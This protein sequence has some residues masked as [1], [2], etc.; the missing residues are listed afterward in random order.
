MKCTVKL[1]GAGGVEVVSAGELRIK[2]GGFSLSYRIEKDMCTL[3]GN[4]DCVRQIR[5]G[6]FYTEMLFTPGRETACVVGGN[7]M[8]GE[9]PL[10]TR[11]I[12]LFSS[13]D[14]LSLEIDYVLAEEEIN[15]KL[16]AERNSTPRQGE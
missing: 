12:D 13:A 5:K 9:I 1:S 14:F 6:S 11:S 3:S 15:L 4:G 2:D 16:T 7:G 8:S 10:F